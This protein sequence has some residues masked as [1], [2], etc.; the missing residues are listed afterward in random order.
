MVTLPDLAAGFFL[1]AATVV[2]GVEVE[3]ISATFLV[4]GALGIDER[5]E[6]TLTGYRCASI[7]FR[8]KI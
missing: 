1:V 8:R 7:P 2:R 3:F 4:R 6:A 5:G